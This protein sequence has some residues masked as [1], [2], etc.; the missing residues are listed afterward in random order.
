MLYIVIEK[1]KRTMSSKSNTRVVKQE[2]IKVDRCNDLNCS[3]FLALKNRHS[4]GACG[5]TIDQ[6][7]MDHMYSDH[8]RM[9]AIYQAEEAAKY[10]KE[11]A[12][13]TVMIKIMTENKTLSGGAAPVPKNSKGSVTVQT[14]K[15]DPRNHVDGFCDAFE[16]VG[17]CIMKCTDVARFEKKTCGVHEN[18]VNLVKY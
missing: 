8:L 6:V 4:P 7:N 15:V 11:C 14:L 16:G 13:L 17:I 1:R 3:D 9:Y 5:K 2:T 10:K 18:A 12:S